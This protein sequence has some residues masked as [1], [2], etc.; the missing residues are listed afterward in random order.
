MRRWI[1]AALAALLPAA[2]RAVQLTDSLQDADLAQSGYLPCHNIDP[3]RLGNY[4]RAWLNTY[5]SNE[6][7]HAK[8]LVYTPPGATDELVILV[9]NQ[10]NIRVL[11]GATGT[12][13][14]S[15]TVQ[16]PFMAFDSNCGDIQYSIGITGTPYIDAATNIMY[17][18][19]KGYRPG[20]GPGDPNNPGVG[21]INGT[22]KLYAVTLPT[23]AD[24]SGFPVTIDGHA[25]DNDPTRYFVGGVV[26]QRP[27]VAVVGNTIV[28]GFGGHCDNFN[29][30]GMLVSVSK[31]AG[32]GVTGVQ[33]MVAS[34]GAPSPIP[35][36]Y[37]NG[38]G[39]KAGI[40]QAGA[41]LAY[42]GGNK[43]YFTTG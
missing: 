42:D 14:Y 37:I 1:S 20:S 18:F 29:Y 30:T 43:L 38:N 33:A 24:I 41:G 26:L 13:K 35:T 6:Y 16:P 27:S 3:A 15:R 17:F 36:D 12:L 23:L 40:W 19:S 21:A 2:V 28:G 31:T 4:T 11:D 39:G 9:S 5:S 10:N 34:P 32:V 7:F 22:Y 25:A 8:P